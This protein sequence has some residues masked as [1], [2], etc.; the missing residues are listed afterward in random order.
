MY[1]YLQNLKALHDLWR[2][3]LTEEVAKHQ[4]W[5]LRPKCHAC[6]H[7]VHEKIELYGTP[8][9]FW[10]YRDEDY[11]GKVKAIARMSAHPKTI[12]TRVGQK[13]R[14]VGALQ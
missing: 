14:I 12:E 5:H 2:L 4:P 11:V 9:N 10:G 6:Q 13:L 1:A 7:L 3:G 8:M